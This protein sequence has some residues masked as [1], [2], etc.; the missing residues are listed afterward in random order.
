M[1]RM[2]VDD[3]F[4]IKGRGLVATGRVEAG[5]LHVGDELQVNGEK[6]VKVDGI[7]AFRKVLDEAKEGDNI[8]VLFA[9]LTREDLKAGDVLSSGGAAPPPPT[10][11]SLGDTAESIGLEG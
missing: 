5:A 9:K 2:T 3:I 8:G 10:D 11:A 7:E 6:S 1:F 4:F